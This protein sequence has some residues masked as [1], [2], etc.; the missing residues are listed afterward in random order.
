M[1]VG[2]KSEIKR[3][4]KVECEEE[5][6]MAVKMRLE[7]EICRRI[8]GV[9]INED[10]EKK[11]EKMRK[12]IYRAE[13]ERIILGGGGDLM[14]AKTGKGGGREERERVVKGRERAKDKKVTRNGRKLLEALEE[15]LII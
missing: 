8:V 2:I 11:L 7:K 4:G 12:W 3:E 10:I 1:L 5:S 6:L 15:V 9:Y 13:R 14:N